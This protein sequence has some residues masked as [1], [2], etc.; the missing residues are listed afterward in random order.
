MTGK[1]SYI[2]QG[3]H[4]VTPYLIVKDAEGLIEFM[5][6]VFE[7]HLIERMERPD[8]RILHAEVR[9][10]DSVVMLAQAGEHP[11]ETLGMLQLYVEDVD[12]AYRRALAAGA[13]SLRVP[14][15]EFYGDRAGGVQDSNGIVW[16]IA[17]HVEDVPPEEM[18]RRAEAQASQQ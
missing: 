13:V 6:E 7:G 10:G 15:D 11:K 14:T 3:Y 1:V 5:Q 16:W 17:T 9:I 12:A 2:P 4:T 8:G 18:Q